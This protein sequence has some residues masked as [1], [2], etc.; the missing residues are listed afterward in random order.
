MTRRN[1]GECSISRS[2]HSGFGGGGEKI[3]F[4][5]PNEKKESEER[6]VMR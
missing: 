4:N 6:A 2:Q 3:T 1:F 5:L